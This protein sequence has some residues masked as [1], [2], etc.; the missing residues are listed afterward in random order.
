MYFGTLL[1]R[2]GRCR[3]AIEQLRQA[4]ALSSSSA[5]ES[6]FLLGLALRRCSDWEQAELHLAVST[7]KNSSCAICHAALG[8]TRI[9]TGDLQGARAALQAAFD[10]SGG[11][12]YGFAD[13]GAGFDSMMGVDGLDTA[14]RRHTTQKLLCDV[15]MSLGPSHAEEALDCFAQLIALVPTGAGGAAPD[16]ADDA[17]LKKRGD[18]GGGDDA[19]GWT[20]TRCFAVLLNNAAVLAASVGRQGVVIS[21]L[22]RAVALR[23]HW[24]FTRRN[25]AAF[26]WA[27]GE[28]KEAAEQLHELRDLLRDGSAT[29]GGMHAA[30]VSATAFRRK[31]ERTVRANT[32]S[33][34]GGIRGSGLPA[35]AVGVSVLYL[36]LHCTRIVLTI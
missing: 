20:S 24:A 13:G 17:V 1:L 26:H 33:W 29:S 36:P 7:R 12:A 8:E 35:E 11:T 2:R 23:P 19:V 27:S 22:H 5:H 4:C 16:G 28:L 9:V 30:S 25:A 18:G 21:W 32:A 34:L 3:A 14:T 6:D 15:L 10:L 31:V